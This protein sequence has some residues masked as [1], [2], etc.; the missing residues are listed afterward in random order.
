M[1][2]HYSKVIEMFSGCPIVVAMGPSETGKSTSIKAALA[3]S[4]NCVYHQ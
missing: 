3:F 1:S 2:Q 4:G